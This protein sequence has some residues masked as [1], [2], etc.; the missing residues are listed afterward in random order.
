MSKVET[1]LLKGVLDPKLKWDTLPFNFT[2][3]VERHDFLTENN[4]Y[5][6]SFRVVNRD[7]INSLT[8][9]YVSRTSPLITLAPGESDE[10][11]GWY[12]FIEVTPDPVTGD[13]LLEVDLCT[14]ENA[15]IKLEPGQIGR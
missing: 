15:Q 1:G 8:Y 2:T 14:R 11:L 6:R 12:S 5:V 9:R 13:G 3:A 10:Q 7:A 4:S